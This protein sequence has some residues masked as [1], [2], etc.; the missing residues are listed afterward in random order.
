MTPNPD[1]GFEQSTR[2]TSVKTDDPELQKAGVI[3]SIS[4]KHGIIG[5]I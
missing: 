4:T 1:F 5:F 2:F 3:S